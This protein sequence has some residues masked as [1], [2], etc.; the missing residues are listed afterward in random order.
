MKKKQTKART[1]LIAS[2]FSW[3][4]M[5]SICA[6]W[7]NRSVEVGVTRFAIDFMGLGFDVK[8]GLGENESAPYTLTNPDVELDER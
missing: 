6:S 3:L 5:A 4:A 8:S 7:L 2:F 1:S